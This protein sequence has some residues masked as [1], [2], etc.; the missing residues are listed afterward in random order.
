MNY[1][2]HYIFSKKEYLPADKLVLLQREVEDLDEGALNALMMV[3][4]RQPFVALIFAIF[5]GEFGVDRFYIGNKELGFAK[6]I[7]LGIGF[8]TMFILVGFLILMGLYI[9]KFIDCFLVI[10][11]CKE[12]NFQRLMEQI[13]QYK[14]FQQGARWE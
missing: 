14:A 9:W 6:L 13:R 8:I 5:F 1:L 10:G 12:A 3:E 11:A 7:T 2:Q 4:L